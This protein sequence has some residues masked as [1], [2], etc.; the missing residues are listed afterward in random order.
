M[1]DRPFRQKFA[2]A[3]ATVLSMQ[4]NLNNARLE[5]EKLRPLVQNKVV[6]EYQLR[7]ANVVVQTAEGNLAQA[8][9]QLGSARIDLG[10]TIIKA[11]TSGFIGRLPKK[12]GSIISPG[13][14]TALTQ[15]SDIRSIHAYFSLGEEDFVNFKAQY[16]GNGVREKLQRLS[17]VR[18]ILANKSVYDL[19]GRVDMIDGQFD[20]R[21]A[22][23][24]LRA[25]FDNKQGLLR[26]GNTGKI[27]M[28]LAHPGAI[29]IPASATVDLQDKIF[30][31]VV[32]S[33]HKARRKFITVIGKTGDKYLVGEGLTTGQ[34][35]VLSGFDR[36]QDGTLIK[37]VETKSGQEAI[38]RN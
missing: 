9:A 23:I 2:S 7:T 11:P 35:I 10:Y 4:G 13:D 31:Y 26:T 24:T 32:G 17:P 38:A 14:V 8:R 21:T 34:L 16:P 12:R 15:L 36:L 27:K 33:D 18:L 30:V 28:A 22:A 25:T 19:P 20:Q 6:S 1:D 5:A 3:A 29:A 37:P